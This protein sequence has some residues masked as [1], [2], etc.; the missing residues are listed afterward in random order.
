[1]TT[2]KLTVVCARC[3]RELSGKQTTA[4]FKVGKHKKPD[5]TPCTGHVVNTHWEKEIQS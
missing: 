2:R 3:A 4:G 5:G 1:M